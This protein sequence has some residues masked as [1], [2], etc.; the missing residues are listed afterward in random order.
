MIPGDVM[1]AVT[2]LQQLAEK[3]GVSLEELCVYALGTPEE[4]AALEGEKTESVAAVEPNSEV[5]TEEESVSKENING[6]WCE[7]AIQYSNPHSRLILMGRN[8][9]QLNKI[10]NLCEDK[11]AKTHIVV[12]D[13]RDKASMAKYLTKFCNQYGIDIAIACAGVSAGTLDGPESPSQVEIIFDTNINGVLNTIM[14]LL[15]YM[16][17]RRR[18]YIV[19]ISSMAGVFGEALRGYLKQYNV[20][21]T[22]VIPGYIKTPMT[23]VNN[24]PMPFIVSAKEAAKKI[25]K[26]V[27]NNKGVIAFP[28]ITYIMLKCLSCL[29]NQ[30]INYIN[31]KLPEKPAFEKDDL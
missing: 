20:N 15:P 12:V 3:N 9:T 29:P 26:A 7:L 25:I 8:S 16:I 11:G 24:F 5:V 28:T 18:G 19:I 4:Q 1:E 30:L 21:T 31:S 10:A 22:V 23:D 14:P 6:L 17:E 2:Q 13:I 27:A